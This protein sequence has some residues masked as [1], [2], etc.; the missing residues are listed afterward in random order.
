MRVIAATTSLKSRRCYKLVFVSLLQDAQ[1]AF[2]EQERDR[3]LTRKIVTIQKAIRGWTYRLK[4]QKMKTCCV[5]LQAALR[6]YIKHKKYIAVSGRHSKI[7]EPSLKH[8]II[9][10]LSSFRCAMDTS[11]CK[12]CSDREF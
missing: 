7:V 2:L 4:F 3:V 1:D 9:C 5:T 8:F 6:S 12:L 11:V 10:V